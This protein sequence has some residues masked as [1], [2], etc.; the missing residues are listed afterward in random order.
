MTFHFVAKK[1]KKNKGQQNAVLDDHR[2]KYLI[3]FVNYFSVL[4]G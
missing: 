2:K 4:E 1:P 3:H